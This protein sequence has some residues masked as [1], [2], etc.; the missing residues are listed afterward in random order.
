ME[1]L[2][3]PE[4]PAEAA[5]WKLD[6]IERLRDALPV[7]SRVLRRIAGGLPAPLPI[8]F[9]HCDE[10][11]IEQSERLRDVLAATE[12]KSLEGAVA[13]MKVAERDWLSGDPQL[14]QR[15]VSMIGQALHF[16]SCAADTLTQSSA[17]SPGFRWQGVTVRDPD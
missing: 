5:A 2:T 17:G 4:C 6:R 14:R 16:M 12:P 13:Q 15:A 11:L 10:V 9:E 3:A 8:G 1:T 7:A